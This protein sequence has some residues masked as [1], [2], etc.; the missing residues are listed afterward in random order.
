[1]GHNWWLVIVCAGGFAALA[2]KD[3]DDEC[4]SYFKK[5]KNG[6]HQ[7]FTYPGNVLQNK[8]ANFGEKKDYI[9]FLGYMTYGFSMYAL[10]ETFYRRPF[11]AMKLGMTVYLKMSFYAHRL[12]II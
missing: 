1:M 7:W 4:V 6:I 12:M 2:L 8:K 3:E 9:E 10:L 11:T 5:F